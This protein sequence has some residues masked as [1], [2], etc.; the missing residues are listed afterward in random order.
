MGYSHVEGDYTSRRLQT[1]ADGIFD[2]MRHLAFL[3]LGVHPDIEK[4]PSF[5][6]LTSLRY[7]ALAVMESLIEIPS[8][9]GLS[10]VSDLII[11]H[12]PRAVMLPTLEPLVN[13][14]NL[15]AMARSGFCCSGFVSG[16][17]SMTESQCL[18]ISGERYPLTCTD[19]R[20][21]TDDRAVVER[22][23]YTVCPDAIPIDHAKMAPSKHSTDELCSGVKYR[24]CTLNS[25]QGIC[26]NS[27]MM[28][29]SC[30]TSAVYMAMRKLQI[31]RGVGERCDP[32]EEAWLGCT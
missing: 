30:D 5:S 11:A 17:C 32:V 18:P 12:L 23:P 14:K 28:V 13:L 26:Y 21:S 8:F 4:L 15:V 10:G 9:E 19:E 27:R 22:F 31:E 6:S 1:M 25:V 2:N 16:T 24:Q 3:H 29:I 20:I 7:M